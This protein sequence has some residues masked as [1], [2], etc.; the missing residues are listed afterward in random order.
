MTRPSTKLTDKYEEERIRTHEQSQIVYLQGQIDELRR[1]INDQTSRYHWAVEQVR[2]SEAA[3]AQIQGTFEKYTEQVNLLIERS[4]RD[5]LELRKEVALAL[6]KIEE[7]FEP[8]REM[9]AQIQQLAES[10]KH[11]RD[12]SFGWGTRIDSLEARIAELQA[13]IK[14]AE[15]RHRQLA[16]HFQSLHEADSQAMQEIRRVSEDIQIEKQSL[17]RQAVEAQQLVSDIYAVLEDHDARILRIDEIR[18]HIELLAAGI[19]EQIADIVR[20][21]PDIDAEMKRVERIATERFLMNQERIEELR[22][23]ADERFVIIEETELQNTTQHSSWIERIDALIRDLEQ[24]FN[25]DI[26]RL[27]EAQ[28]DLAMFILNYSEKEMKAIMT[29]S[30]AVALGSELY[31]AGKKE[32]DKIR[33]RY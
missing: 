20:K 3:V 2:K 18:Q 11:D 19:P 15:E 7:S 4:R 10:R 27:E 16:L 24:R 1:Q 33:D 12:F 14:E 17:R 22:R 32:I 23:Q 31:Q 6:N 29:I 9:Q 21:F 13:Q 26:N 25:R 8:I 30:N 5:V 28:H